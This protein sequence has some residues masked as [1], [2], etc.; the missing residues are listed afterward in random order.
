M[1]RVGFFSLDYAGGAPEFWSNLGTYFSC[2]VTISIAAT[3]TA[4]QFSVP[5]SAGT[6]SVA[7]F[8]VKQYDST[9][10]QGPLTLAPV[11]PPRRYRA[12][13]FH[14]QTVF[15]RIEVRHCGQQVGARLP[16]SFRRPLA[17][18]SHLVPQ[19]MNCNLAV[20]NIGH[21]KAR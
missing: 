18:Q 13:E 10:N 5:L 12:S 6:C 21:K 14:G 9:L 2:P 20:G 19:T 17:I 8:E 3:Q 7:Y 15:K 1:V 11:G 16:Q 4:T